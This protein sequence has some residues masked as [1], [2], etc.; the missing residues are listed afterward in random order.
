MARKRYCDIKSTS[1]DEILETANRHIQNIT[2]TELDMIN[3]RDL[4][5]LD[6]FYVNMFRDTWCDLRDD[7]IV[8]KKL[9][10]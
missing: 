2:M 5:P 9:G 8:M 1:L 3:H 4:T 7:I 6:R 10:K